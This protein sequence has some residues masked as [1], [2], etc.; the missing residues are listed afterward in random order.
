MGDSLLVLTP[1]PLQRLLDLG[2]DHSFSERPPAEARGLIPSPRP[3]SITTEF[4]FRTTGKQ[5]QSLLSISASATRFKVRRQNVTTRKP[6][7]I[8]MR[9]IPS[10]ALLA[11]A[12]KANLSIT[13]MGTDADSTTPRTP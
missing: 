5:S 2:S 12:I 6:T 1:T 10:A 9:S 13:A 11:E 7:S 3:P 8:S 4:T